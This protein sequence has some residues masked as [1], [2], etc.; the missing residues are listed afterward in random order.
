MTFAATAN[1]ILHTGATPVFV[2]VELPSMTI[3]PGQIENK[4]TPKTKAILPVHLCGRPCNMD[5]IMAIA[6]NA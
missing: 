1:A 2:D 3:D 5:R 6:K 4:I